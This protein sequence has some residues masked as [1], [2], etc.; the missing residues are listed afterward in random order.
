MKYTKPE[1]GV[2][3]NAKALLEGPPN[4]SSGSADNF[5]GGSTGQLLYTIPPAYDLDD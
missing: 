4:K 1:I 2:L 5:S 3:G